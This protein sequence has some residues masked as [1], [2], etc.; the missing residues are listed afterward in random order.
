MGSEGASPGGQQLDMLPALGQHQRGT[1]LVQRLL[2]I[3]ENELVAI[4]VGSQLPVQR[5]VRQ[6]RRLGGLFP[7]NVRGPSDEALGEERPGRLIAWLDHESGRSQLEGGDVVQAI[8]SL[9]RSR[10]PEEEAGAN[11]P[12]H[13]L[14][15]HGRRMV[16]LIH[17]HEAVVRYPVVHSSAAFETPDARNVEPAVRGALPPAD[18]ALLIKLDSEEHRELRFPLV[19]KLLSM[20]QDQGVHLP[21]SD[22]VDAYEGLA[23]VLLS[24]VDHVNQAALR[25]TLSSGDAVEYGGHR[26]MSKGR[27]IRRY[28]AEERAEGVRV[29]LALGPA[30]AAKKLGI[31][32]GTLSFWAYVHRKTNG[33]AAPVA[34]QAAGCE[35][36][37]ESN[38][39]PSAPQDAVTSRSEV[40]GDPATTAPSQNVAKV[41]TPSQ[42]VQALEYA[43]KHGPAAASRKFGISRFSLREWRRKAQQHAEGKRSDNPLAGSDEN[44]A[45]LHDQ[46]ILAEWRAHP[47]LGPT[48]VRN[49]LRRQ[50]FKV[51]THTVRCVLDANGYVTPRSRRQEAHDNF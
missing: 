42:R 49:Q 41:Y 36:A 17:D 37:S 46:R 28:S 50:G 35:S 26:M 47:G 8:T 18:L 20:D 13:P 4:L 6:R 25:R 24:Y 44:A 7:A 30:A 48:Q 11:L 12:E 16:A 43:A 38:S 22:H 45:E 39:A 33:G 51:S 10:E 31:P 15:H 21:L 40:A 29:T 5:Q 34:A 19:N 9:R 1:P 23:Y 3:R 14:E 27:T 2:E 32:D